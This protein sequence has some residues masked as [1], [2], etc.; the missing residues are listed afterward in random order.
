MSLTRDAI[1]AIPSTAPVKVDIE[2]WGGSVYVRKLSA[3]ESLRLSAAKRALTGPES[4]DD[5]MALAL[6]AYVCDEHGVA[7]FTLE[8]ART[9]A[10]NNASADAVWR[11][12]E[13]GNNLNG[14]SANAGQQAAKNSKPN[15]SD[16]SPT[17]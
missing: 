8:E 15:P 16:T 5:G 12:M 10:A 14:M 2:E 4:S 9:I 3:L 6:S 13:V 11:I 1:L 7:L 17:S